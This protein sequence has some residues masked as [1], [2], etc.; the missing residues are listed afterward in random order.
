MSNAIAQ[1]TSQVTV[2]GV[3]EDNFDF[4]A[5][6]KRAVSRKTGKS[7]LTRELNR[8]KLTDVVSSMCGEYRSINAAIYGKTERLPSEI[9]GKITEAAER[10]IGR[11]LATVNPANCI[12]HRRA[13]HHDHKNMQVTERVTAVGEN[14]LSLE[15]QRL[16]ATLF[17]GEAERKLK[18]FLTDGKP[19]R[20]KQMQL[21]GTVNR[22]QMT[23]NFILGEIKHQE[24]LQQAK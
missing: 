9:H 14:M 24:S 22:C 20:D 16:G 13:F 15:E 23:L 5:S 17:L 21:Q 12:T 3:G 4:D 8:I 18:A 10:E 1:S 7:G 2:S 11:L 19:D 6:A